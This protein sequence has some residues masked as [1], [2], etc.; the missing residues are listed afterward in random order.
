[1]ELFRIALAGDG[2]TLEFEADSDEL[3]KGAYD[4]PIYAFKNSVTGESLIVPAHLVMYIKSR[5]L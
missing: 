1:M 2:G 5:P 4:M 3:I